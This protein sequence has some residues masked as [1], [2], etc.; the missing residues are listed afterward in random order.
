MTVFR[1]LCL[2]SVLL[3]VFTVN[4]QQPAAPAAPADNPF[5]T[6]SPLPYEAPPFDQIRLEHYAPAFAEGMRLQLAE[7]AAIT[8]LPGTP[9]FADTIEAIERSGALLSRVSAVFFAMTQ[10]HTNDAL[11]AIQRDVAP[12]LAA[13]RDAIMLDP[14]LFR[15]VASLFER[16]DQL[17]LDAEQHAVLD[18]YH[19]DFVRAGAQL[20]A[21]TQQKLRELNQ[22]LSKLTTEFQRLLLAAN[23]EGAVVVDD[24]VQLAGLSD[25]EREAAA[26][27][28][29][30]RKLEGKWLLSL[31]NTTQQPQLASLQDRALRERLLA[32]AVARGVGGAN[33]TTPLLPRI[34]EL[35]AERAKLLGFATHADYVL[36]D[37]MAKTPDRAKKLLT[38]L[39]PAATARAR[40]EAAK[41]QAI[42]DKLQQ[43]FPLGPHDWQFYA[44]QVRKAEFDLDSEQLKP[45]FALD[46]VLQDGVFFMAKELYGLE[47]RPRTDLPLHHPD[48]QV[49]E[50]FEAGKPL[51]LFYVDF[52]QRDSKAGGAWMNSFVQ[53]SLLL[54][55]RPVVCNTCNFQKPVAGQ[56][57]LLSLDDVSTLFHE[58]GHAL[59]GLLSEVRYPRLSGTSVPRDFVELPSQFH[60]HWA[61]EPAML[62]RYARHWQTG[63][64]IPAALIEKIRA[65]RTFDQGYAT[66]EYLASALLDLAWHTLP[67]GSVPQD[68]EAFEKQTLEAAG[69]ALAT[70]PPR[71]RSTYFR[72][73]WGGGY[74]A[75]YYAYMWA[76]VLDQ[77]AFAFVLQNG[78]MTKQN[79]QRFREM[80]LSRGGIGDAAAMYRAYRGADPV[81]EPLLKARGL[82]GPGK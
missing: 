70:V 32:A 25:A 79:G 18:R 48:A 72:H 24:V 22:E 65:M 75:G 1:S 3:L 53:P 27:A 50:V 17:S 56:P 21:P 29:K 45:Y 60:E 66:T 40:A 23:K 71:Y 54:G 10:A 73:V 64:V 57:A 14:A 51:A 81:I 36:D 12:K 76:E 15:R 37:Q 31:R 82:L 59:H 38:D 80:I 78:G 5:F 8:A 16:R 28:A 13:H 49:F 30:E 33:A 26:A 41:M 20:D 34:A 19:R 6:K 69:V 35:R 52:F 68:V 63:E 61:T 67:A 9:T 42:V 55:K 39:V 2:P 43:P 47:F 62:Q 77:D 58:F 46:R 4:A 11:Q 44:E 74:A 7:I